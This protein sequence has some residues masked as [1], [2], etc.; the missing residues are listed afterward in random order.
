MVPQIKMLLNQ[1]NAT[2]I[3]NDIVTQWHSEEAAQFL[4]KLDPQCEWIEGDKRIVGH[5]N[6]LTA[7]QRKQNTE[8]HYQL[9]AELVSYSCNQIHA[10]FASSWQFSI[11][12]QWYR[13]VGWVELSFAPNGL[14][15]MITIDISNRPISAQERSLY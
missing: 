7:V 8:L 12:G 11:T 15:D 10:K 9:S 13:S 1:D 5:A 4:D 3:L 6:I 14:I 2:T